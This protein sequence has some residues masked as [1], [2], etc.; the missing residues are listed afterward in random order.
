MKKEVRTICYDSD[1]QLEAYRLEGIVQPFPNHFHECYVI[2]YMVGG[3]RYL[4][5]K[6]KEYTLNKGDIV[7]FNPEDNHAYAQRGD[8]TLHYLGVNISKFVM[9]E[10]SKEITGSKELPL[11]NQTVVTDKELSYY[12]QS[13]HENIMNGSG[14]LE[15]EELLIFMLSLLLQQYCEPSKESTV[16]YHKE[17]E[18]T[19]DFIEA[20][21]AEPISLKQLCGCAGMSKSALLR[22]FIKLKGMTPYRYLQTIR[23]EAAKNLL[24]KETSLIDTAMQTG[25]SDQSHF[26]KF[27]NMFNGLTPGTYRDIFLS[28][29]R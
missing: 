27:F 22:A 12:I 9:L 6:N 28:K 16:D 5:C 13:L 24:K 19:C 10:L 26:T 20:H 23:V 18:N 7:L 25:F 15:K 3:K 11:F 29:K 2:G 8:E 21:F 4:S 17:I 1:L 14:G